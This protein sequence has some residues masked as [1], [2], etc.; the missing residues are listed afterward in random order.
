MR[1]RYYKYK[2]E[3]ARQILNDYNSKMLIKDIKEKYQISFGGLYGLIKR[4][5]GDQLG[6]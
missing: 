6:K 2:G 3:L 5:Q 4:E 1:G